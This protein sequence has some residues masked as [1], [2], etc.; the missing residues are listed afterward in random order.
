MD[1]PWQRHLNC[2]SY[3][4]FGANERLH[5]SI[6]GRGRLDMYIFHL[7]KRLCNVGELFSCL[8]WK[9]YHKMMIHDN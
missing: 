4:G 2:A 6:Q 8:R 3:S 5:S 7:I 9:G 1:H